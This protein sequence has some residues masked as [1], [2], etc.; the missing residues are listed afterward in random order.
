M[1]EVKPWEF[2]STKEVQAKFEAAN[3]F[4]IKQ[5]AEFSVWTGELLNEIGGL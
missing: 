2:L 4:C 1:I 5:E 3:D